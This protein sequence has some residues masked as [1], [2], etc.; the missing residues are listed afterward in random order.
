LR[1][2]IDAPSA[3]AGAA[4][5]RLAVLQGWVPP[6]RVAAAVAVCSGSEP[7]EVAHALR[8]RRPDG[9]VVSD[10]RGARLTAL[11]RLAPSEPPSGLVDLLTGAG[12]GPIAVSDA[13]GELAA[14]GDHARRADDAL[15]AIRAVAQLR[16]GTVAELGAWPL[17]ARLWIA[18]GRPAVPAELS[19]LLAQLDGERLVST[20]EAVLDGAGEL[21][22]VASALH[23]HRA[24]VYRRLAR[25][26]QLCGASLA[27]GEDRLRL[28]LAVRLWRLGGSVLPGVED[29]R[30]VTNV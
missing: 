1:A 20:L 8:R 27:R 26:E 24:T 11:V 5:Q 14:T 29:A 3:L 16:S 22:A 21:G 23:V 15:T 19:A 10:E 17:V 30:S 18:R 12:A 25:I 4:A 7:A 13:F 6:L 9:E 2:L 28:H